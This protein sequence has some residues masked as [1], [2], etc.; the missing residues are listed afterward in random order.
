MKIIFSARDYKNQSFTK[1]Q[2]VHNHNLTLRR[3]H[4]DEYSFCIL[5]KSKI[6]LKYLMIDKMVN[7]SL[8]GIKESCQFPPI[9]TQKLPKK[10]W[11]KSFTDTLALHIYT[12]RYVNKG[13]LSSLPLNLESLIG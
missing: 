9:T 2:F 13:I 7:I 5:N 4:R 6:E 1:I 3:Y 10:D 11:L 8:S 12:E